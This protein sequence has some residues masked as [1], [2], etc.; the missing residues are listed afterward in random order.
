MATA[1]W[2]TAAGEVTPRLGFTWK[3]DA[4]LAR[5]IAMY[6]GEERYFDIVLAERNSREILERSGISLHEAAKRGLRSSNWF[7]D[8]PAFKSFK[9][10]G[11][12]Q[13]NSA[14]LFIPH[15]DLAGNCTLQYRPDAPFTPEQ[16]GDEPAKA[17][18][19]DWEVG[20]GNSVSIGYNAALRLDTRAGKRLRLIIV[21]GT[22]QAICADIYAPGDCIVVGIPGI[23]NGQSEGELAADLLVLILLG[24]IIEV[25]IIPDGDFKTKP[26]VWK[27]AALLAELIERASGKSVRFASLDE[28]EGLDDYLGAYRSDERRAELLADLIAAAGALP[29]KPSKNGEEGC[30]A[31]QTEENEWSRFNI[32]I[33]VSDLID[34][35]DLGADLVEGEYGRYLA[36]TVAGEASIG[37]FSDGAEYLYADK[38]AVAK[39]FGIEPNKAAG[40]TKLLIAALG[41]KAAGGGKAVYRIVKHFDGQYAE[42]AQWLRAHGGDLDELRDAALAL[43]I[44]R[45]KNPKRK[46]VRFEN[47]DEVKQFNALPV[48]QDIDLGVH[49]TP[50]HKL[51]ASN[52]GN[53]QMTLTQLREALNNHEGNQ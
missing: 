49:A 22:R 39:H 46:T 26:H 14:G 51:L 31:T 41:G 9:K 40:S 3:T 16:R 5:D 19:Y 53:T 13:R 36:E 18:K 20:A 30:T 2:K 42:A 12:E 38:D 17:R 45:T 27:G 33:G 44:G 28:P 1:G 48:F 24:Y 47:L 50:A 25:I 10:K 21:E 11:Y 6:G 4:D 29:A 43:N 32:H 7:W 8:D 52:G 34:S 35:L 37:R 15:Y 23:W